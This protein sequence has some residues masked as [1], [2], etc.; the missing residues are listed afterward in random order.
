MVTDHKVISNI[1]VTLETHAGAL[2]VWQLNSCI[3]S[4]KSFYDH[5]LPKGVFRVNI[6]EIS[7]MQRW[8][9]VILI[10]YCHIMS[11]CQWRTGCE[12]QSALLRTSAMNH[13]PTCLNWPEQSL[14][15]ICCS[16]LM[17]LKWSKNYTFSASEMPGLHLT[18]SLIYR[19]VSAKF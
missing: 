8:L 17:L 10:L 9:L 3:W 1:A 15:L 7:H 2:V 4:L 13:A 11:Q 12:R 19:F 5:S 18:P 6:C 16:T 14:A